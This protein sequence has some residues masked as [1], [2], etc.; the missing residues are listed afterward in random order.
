M[1]STETDAPLPPSSKDLLLTRVP[2][3]TCLLNKDLIPPVPVAHRANNLQVEDP[4]L[5]AKAF[6]QDKVNLLQEE[7]PDLQEV[8]LQAAHHQ[9]AILWQP[10]A[11]LQQ[12]VTICS[13]TVAP[14]EHETSPFSSNKGTTEYT[15]AQ[16]NQ[17]V[18]IRFMNRQ[19]RCQCGFCIITATLPVPDLSV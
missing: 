1:D 3:E 14:V 8:L 11:H 5:P 17:R 18:T 19:A 7:G 2:E 15:V 4:V 13:A 10:E 16:R 6:P 12:A 9:V